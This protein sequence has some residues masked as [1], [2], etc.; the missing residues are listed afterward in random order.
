MASNRWSKYED[1]N[2][3]ILEILSGGKHLTTW[4][5]REKLRKRYNFPLH[6]TTVLSYLNALAGQGH[7]KKIKLINDKNEVVV[8][9][10]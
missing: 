9:K 10:R 5:V 4:A 1:I 3:Y 2:K 8:W 7:I 6:H